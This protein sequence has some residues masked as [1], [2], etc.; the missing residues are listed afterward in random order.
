MRK[1]LKGIIVAAALLLS[2]V[3]AQ[4]QCS[5]VTPS[6][7]FCGNPG[8]ASGFSAPASPTAMFD[9]AFSSTVGGVLYRGASTWSAL[10]DVATGNALISGGVSTA[11]A[12]GKI[13]SAALNITTTSCT[14]QF[15]TAISAGGVG[16]C[17]TD[18]LASAQHANQ[19]TTTT[20]LHGNAAGNP[21]WAQVSLSVDVTGNLPVTN[22]NSGTSA[23]STTYWRGDATWAALPGSFT[24]FANPSA[25]IGLSAVNGSATTAMRSDGAPA[26]SQAIVP[27][28]TA[29]HT[30]S[31]GLR[32]ANS[33][34]IVARNAANTADQGLIAYDSSNSIIY[35]PGAFAGVHFFNGGIIAPTADNATAL[36]AVSTN[37]WSNIYSLLYTGGALI[38]VTVGNTNTVTLKDTLF[39]LQDDGDATKQA[40]FQLSGI[41]TATTRVYALPDANGT[42][43][44]TAGST[45]PTV[46][47]G[48][49][50]YGSGA[51]VLSALPDVATG[52]ALISGGMST[53]PAWGKIGL[54][55]HVTGTLPVANGGT[56]ITAFGTGVATALGVNVGSAGAFVTFGGALGSPS[57][58]GT[59]P[60]HTLGG[61]ISGGGNQI[62]NVVIGASTPLAGSFT[63]VTVTTMANVATTSAVC[64]NTG[65]G[66]LT[67]DGT[68]GTCTVSLLAAKDLVAR[69]SDREGFDI[70]MKM[71][72]WRYT[73][74]KGLPTYI[75]GEQIGFVADYAAEKD[76]RV[77]AFNHDGSLSGFRYE[78]YT[79]ALT[80]AFK[81]DEARITQL[82]VVNG[83]LSARVSELENT[84]RRA[85]QAR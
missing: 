31:L 76:A 3:A 40:S 38:T 72:A 51:N 84:M 25:T 29:L 49:L 7:F 34:S 11:P 82:E 44:L 78:Q 41:S 19:G 61:T 9:R 66:L 18:T 53:A 46:A 59:L 48:D 26:L 14:N 50:L 4:A 10:P 13:T 42:I 6:G 70:V 71:D 74:K 47:T 75:A 55:T 68:L 56:G 32:L 1:F 16:T 52:N 73:M 64:Y 80:G 60:A 43:A 39:T 30:F 77:V 58:V 62:N 12:W 2:P 81:Y 35:G 8:A 57:S 17:T 67:Y 65:T 79:A 63:T 36:G 37:R 69:L 21:I 27:I 83:N 54:T 45:I 22:L 20:V 15:V 33:Q 23:S 24:G 28:W 85:S 5:G